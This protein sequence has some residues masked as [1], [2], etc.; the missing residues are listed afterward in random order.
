MHCCIEVTPARALAPNSDTSDECRIRINEDVYEYRSTDTD[1][2]IRILALRPGIGNAP[3]HGDLYH[4]DLDGIYPP[5]KALSYV[6]GDPN[7]RDIFTCNSKSVFL[8]V[9]LCDALKRI[10]LPEDTLHVWA[11][12]ICINQQDTHERNRQVKLMGRV[13]ASAQQVVVWLGDDPTNSAKAVFEAE[14]RQ[15]SNRSG[16]YCR[17]PGTVFEELSMCSWF[18]RV[19]VIQEAI[20][21]RDTMVFWGPEHCISMRDLWSLMVTGVSFYDIHPTQRQVLEWLLSTHP[22]VIEG[23]LDA[24]SVLHWVRTKHCIDDRD[25]IYSILGLPYNDSYP[26]WN[27]CIKELKPDYNISVSELFLNVATVAARYGAILDILIAVH[28]CPD[29][30]CWEDNAEPSWVPRWDRYSAT[31]FKISCLTTEPLEQV[32]VSRMSLHG[33]AIHI[34]GTHVDG[35]AKFS[36]TSLLHSNGDLNIDSVLEF[37]APIYRKNQGKGLE[38]HGFNLSICLIVYNPS[39]EENPGRFPTSYSTLLWCMRQN[40]YEKERSG[41]RT[42]RNMLES[43]EQSIQWAIKAL[44]QPLKQKRELCESFVINSARDRQFLQCRR[45]F[46]TKASISGLGPEAMREND[47]VITLESNRVPLVI[48]AEGS[49]YRFVGTA[50]LLQD[51]WHDACEKA[52]DSGAQVKEIEIR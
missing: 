21:G 43:F 17:D 5:Y 12:G 4:V 23:G 7:H 24:F 2:T 45:L 6:W 47:I 19:W 20:L 8:T 10:R 48:R 40:L 50:F 46:R 27:S 52:Q 16:E 35:V 38:V 1:S 9:S 32:S 28:H 37:W 42:H 11:D 25:R 41:D 18:H 22:S 39:W 31:N 29:L 14:S 49:F 3:L 15:L 36:K 13:Y 26:W 44:R 51:E 30:E 34:N 33:K